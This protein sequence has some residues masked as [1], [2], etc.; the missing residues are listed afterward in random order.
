M[1]G[2]A[3]GAGTSEAHRGVEDS[4]H[5]GKLP[6]GEGREVFVEFSD[7][8]GGKKKRR[9]ARLIIFGA[10]AFT[11]TSASTPSAIVES[12]VLIILHRVPC[13]FNLGASYWANICGSSI[14][15]GP[16]GVA[17]IIDCIDERNV[18]QCCLITVF[19]E[20]VEKQFLSSLHVWFGAP[21]Q[22]S[23][24]SEKIKLTCSG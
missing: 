24:L 9:R 15:A 17:W 4:K 18:A 14:D 20:K 1:A 23:D 13:A 22:T 7:I 2:E 12:D 6:P 19:S 21:V 8:K 5:S 11:I 10:P 16:D 3:V